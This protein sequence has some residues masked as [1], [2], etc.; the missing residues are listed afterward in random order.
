MN[1]TEN[2]I[3]FCGH[4]E[5]LP[6][7]QSQGE[8]KLRCALKGCLEEGV[9]LTQCRGLFSA[10]SSELP[11]QVLKKSL[12]PFAKIHQKSSWIPISQE[13]GGQ[14]S[15]VFLNVNSVAKRLG[16]EKK[17]VMSWG[18]DREF[19][20][21]VQTYVQQHPETL[22]GPSPLLE[23]EFER[24]KCYTKKYGVTT[25]VKTEQRTYIHLKEK[26][27]GGAEKKCKLAVIFETNE[28]VARLV[29]NCKN[30]QQAQSTLEKYKRSHQI[31]D[32]FPDS[33]RL[34]RRYDLL[35]MNHFDK[36]QGIEIPQI[37][38]YDKLYDA[39]DL[40]KIMSGPKPLDIPQ[41]MILAQ[42]MVDALNLLHKKDICHRDIKP[43]NVLIRSE[44]NQWRAAL[45]DLESSVS[46]LEIAKGNFPVRC[47]TYPYYSPQ[48][49]QALMEKNPEKA[50][51]GKEE[52]I[53]MLGHTL[54]YLFFDRKFPEN[55]PPFTNLNAKTYYQEIATFQGEAAFDRSPACGPME[56]L[57]WEML[58]VDP[59]KRPT[60]SEV[61]ERFEVMA[62]EE[63]DPS[64]P[65]LSLLQ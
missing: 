38:A 49:A 7:G 52:D 48:K 17:T 39:G 35:L 1:I 26:I 31:T 15:T 16:V 21:N 40:F 47:G 5:A 12:N 22:P 24:G 59:R 62:K 33:D 57:I 25:F 23:R 64:F 6:V 4:L 19:I 37:I 30:E 54:F 18:E 61:L 63:A 53:W 65:V 43:L 41:K 42:D 50:K 60:I 34:V 36:K 45:C 2:P 56:Q 55:L 14:S 58:Q 51:N 32:S 13:V 29:T 44:N 20:Q 11:L 27:G 28:R 9:D 10:S 46:L 8:K 3:V